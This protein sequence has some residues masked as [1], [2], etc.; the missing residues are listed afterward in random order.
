MIRVLAD[1][2][3]PFVTGVINRARRQIAAEHAATY[4]DWLDVVEYCQS[5]VRGRQRRGGGSVEDE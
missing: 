5:R 2:R 3:G 1:L 4:A